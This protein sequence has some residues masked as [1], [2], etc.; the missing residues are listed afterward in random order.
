MKRTIQLKRLP[1]PDQADALQRTLERANAA[2]DYLSQVAWETHTFRK[3]AL[4]KVYYQAV[5]ATFGLAA[6]MVIRALAKVGA[7][8]QLDTKVKRTFRPHAAFAYD[9]RIR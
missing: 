2:C 3:F 5:R 1:T 4:Q 8:Y 6:Q 7:A 9:D